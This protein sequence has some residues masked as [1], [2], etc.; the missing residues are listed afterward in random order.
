MN[1]RAPILSL[2]VLA[3][4]LAVPAWPFDA[5]RTT[6]GRVVHAPRTPWPVFV[7]ADAVDKIGVAKVERWRSRPSRRGTL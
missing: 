6:G 1:T 7:Q 2:I 4:L 5:L 3:L